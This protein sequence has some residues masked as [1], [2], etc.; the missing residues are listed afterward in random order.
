MDDKL[1]KLMRRYKRLGGELFI[2]RMP[3]YTSTIADCQAVIDKEYSERGIKFDFAIFDY[4]DIMGAMSGQ[5]EEVKRIS[6]V[7]LDIKNFLDFNKMESGWTPSHTK[8]NAQAQ[9]HRA[10][11]YTQYDIAKCTDKIRHVDL[12][13]GLQESE[14]EIEANIIR[15]EV[16]EVRNGKHGKVLFWIDWEK[17]QIREFAASELKDYNE[18]YKIRY[19]DHA[20]DEDR[21]RLPVRKE[22]KNDL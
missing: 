12:A 6:D 15:L 17:Q 13:L 9:K 22:R 21:L 10:T 1:L 20:P 16:I 8:A 19:E 2:K 3:A 14:E 11:R 18:T 7:Y 4:P 5:T